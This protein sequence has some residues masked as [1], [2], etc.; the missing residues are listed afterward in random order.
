[1]IVKIGKKLILIDEME[2][3][4]LERTSTLIVSR[5][6][7]YWQFL[8]KSGHF[9]NKRTISHEETS[10]FPIL[11]MTT[12]TIW[13]SYDEECTFS[14]TCCCTFYAHLQWYSCTSLWSSDFCIYL[15]IISPF[16]VKRLF[17]RSE[18]QVADAVRWCWVMKGR[19]RAVSV[20]EDRLRGPLLPFQ[21]EYHSNN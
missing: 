7:H 14:S 19:W 15:F 6:L 3:E 5:S 21:K 18:H 17:F 11:L 9:W 13:R 1:M 4:L 20:M 12:C 8:K 10:Y 16:L 2:F